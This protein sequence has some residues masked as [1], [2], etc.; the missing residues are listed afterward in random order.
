MAV[1]G[2]SGPVTI[3]CSLWENRVAPGSIKRKCAVC[4]VGVGVSPASADELRFGARVVCIPCGTDEAPGTRVEL[5]P[6]TRLEAARLMG[7]PL[8]DID[9]S[10]EALKSIPLAEHDFSH[11]RKP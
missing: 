2:D 1:G 7:V 11:E 6:G 9:R 4:D 10:A 8:A 5:L 3:L